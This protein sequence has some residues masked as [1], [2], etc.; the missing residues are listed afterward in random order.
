MYKLKILTL[1]LLSAFIAVI[2]SACDKD[3]PSVSMEITTEVDNPVSKF[4]YG[5][6]EAT[7]TFA[8]SEDYLEL[9]I[10]SFAIVFNNNAELITPTRDDFKLADEKSTVSLVEN[11]ETV[12][13]EMPVYKYSFKTNIIG[14]EGVL[15]AFAICPLIDDFEEK[16]NEDCEIYR[17]YHDIQIH[18]ACP[19]GE[20]I[21]D[22]TVLDLTNVFGYKNQGSI[23]ITLL[24]LYLLTN[25]VPTLKVE[26][27]TANNGDNLPTFII[28]TKDWPYSEVVEFFN[29]L[30]P[31]GNLSIPHIY[32]L[33]GN[34][35]KD[36]I[37]QVDESK[38]NDLTIKDGHT[39]I[40]NSPTK[41]KK[42]PFE[43]SA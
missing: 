21:V 42:D 7:I 23:P 25:E 4:P 38:K 36:I 39:F 30:L 26:Y 17:G 33:M 34:S 6:A 8:C 10:P 16:I 18:A 13:R 15:L 19:D 5:Y 27:K 9:S 24:N 37:D 1:A 40:Q 20:Y 28:D 31:I 32:G 43:I 22:N 12:K 3:E 2:M 11:G 41:N 29:G 35:R 14:S